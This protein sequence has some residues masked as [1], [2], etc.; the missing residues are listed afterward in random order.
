MDRYFKDFEEQKKAVLQE[1]ESKEKD[2]KDCYA[3]IEKVKEQV[4]WTLVVS[5]LFAKSIVFVVRQ[6]GSREPK[7]HE[8]AKVGSA[9]NIGIYR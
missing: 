8:I 5:R 6:C 7:V 9:N 3:D 1:C 2:K 4:N